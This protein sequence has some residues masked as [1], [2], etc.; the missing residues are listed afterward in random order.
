MMESC[1]KFAHAVISHSC[2][3]VIFNL[4]YLIVSFVTVNNPLCIKISLSSNKRYFTKMLQ[5]DRKCTQMSGITWSQTR[6]DL[7]I[8]CCAAFT[9][10]LILLLFWHW[11]E[12]LW[13]W[14]FHVW[15]YRILLNN[16]QQSLALNVDRKEAI[17]LTSTSI[18][19]CP[20]IW[21][22]SIWN[23]HGTKCKHLW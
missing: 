16:A 15:I 19:S 9:V 13:F 5:N 21:Y 3:W 6:G 12:P 23:H 11:V 17:Y 22:W 18:D 7:G 20:K 8:N 1:K 10:S 4:K 2:F 14:V